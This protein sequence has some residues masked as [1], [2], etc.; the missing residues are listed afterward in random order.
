M[1]RSVTGQGGWGGVGPGGGAG[2]GEVVGAG[3][4]HGVPSLQHWARVGG[5]AG[6]TVRHGPATRAD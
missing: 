3:A 4:G 5:V 6:V 1:C 2:G